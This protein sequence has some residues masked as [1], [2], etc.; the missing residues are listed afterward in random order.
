MGRRAATE[1]TE[2]QSNFLD[3]CFRRDRDELE[4]K[5]PQEVTDWAEAND[6]PPS[7]AYQWRRSDLFQAEYR[8]MIGEATVHPARIN[9][10]M[11]LLER[12]AIDDDG[13]VNTQALNKLIEIQQTYLPINPIQQAEAGIA[14]L[15]DEALWELVVSAAELRGWEVNINGVAPTLEDANVSPPA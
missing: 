6:V 2:V 4:S 9:R 15:S 5:E 11:M 8:R 7:T 13:R 10:Q 1:L 14:D 3:W 12:A